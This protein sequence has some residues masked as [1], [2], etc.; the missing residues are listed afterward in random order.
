VKIEASKIKDIGIRA[1]IVAAIVAIGFSSVRS[2]LGAYESEGQPFS[3]EILAEQDDVVWGFDFLPDGRIVFTER[4]GQLRILDPGT[5]SVQ[6]VQGVPA[7]ARAGQGGLLDVRVHPAFNENGWIYL[8]YS[9]TVDR[10][11]TTAL[12]RGRL[13]GLVLKDYRKLFS[14]WEPNRNNIHF[15]SRIEFDGSGKL[16]ISV[17]DRNERHYAQDLRY[18]NGKILRLNEDGSVPG[19]NPFTQNPDAKPEIWSY[20]HRNPQGLV[21]HPVTGELWESE[22]GPRGGDEINVIHPGA[23]YGW[24]V[25]TY[26]REY[27]GPKIGEGTEKAGMEQPIAYYVPSISPS[28]IAFYSGNAF[29]RWRGSLFVA[30]LSGQHLRRLVIDQNNK[31]VKEEELLS[32]LGVHFRHVRPGPEGYLYFSTNDGKIARLVPNL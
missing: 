2:L 3:V 29:P 4:D 17:G 25:I 21:K 12:G 24:P 7:V 23:N 16:F 18:H 31:V 27:W 5:K 11:M 9:E 15:G 22:F 8:T 13:D 14:A 19:D 26:G 10:G 1:G 20:G 30:N 28:G 32:D 6:T